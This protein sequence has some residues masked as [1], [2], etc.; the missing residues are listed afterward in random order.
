VN[1]EMDDDAQNRRCFEGTAAAGAQCLFHYLSRIAQTSGRWPK[2][3]AVDAY[4]N[5]SGGRGLQF[6][7]GKKRHD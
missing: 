4:L 6:Y 3:G 7:C 5:T 1:I 2:W